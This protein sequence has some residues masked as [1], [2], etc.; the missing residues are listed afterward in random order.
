MEDSSSTTLCAPAEDFQLAVVEQHNL[1]EKEVV[2]YL[3]VSENF[4]KKTT[5][6]RREQRPCPATLA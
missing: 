4:A 1:F 6:G 3:P 5:A 2:E